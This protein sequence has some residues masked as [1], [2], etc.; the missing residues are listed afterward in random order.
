MTEIKELL[1]NI[2]TNPACLTQIDWREETDWFAKWRMSQL[3]MG[4]E[5]DEVCNIVEGMIVTSWYIACQGDDCDRNSPERSLLD[6]SWDGCYKCYEWRFDTVEEPF[7]SPK[8]IEAYM[9]GLKQLRENVNRHKRRLEELCIKAKGLGEEIAE[10]IASADCDGLAERCKELEAEC[11]EL[12][13]K[14]DEY[15]SAYE[16]EVERCA[17]LRL[18]I[19]N[20]DKR[21]KELETALERKRK[22]LIPVGQARTEA[23]REFVEQIIVYAEKQPVGAAR[24]IKDLLLVKSFNHHIS[25]ECLTDELRE[26]INKL[27]QEKQT[28]IVINSNTTD[29]RNSSIKTFY[30]AAE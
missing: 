20:K 9:E 25:E 24:E 19:R 14:N 21:I 6:E 8:S 16:G 18:E 7:P 11:N 26:R 27:G 29:I 10:K 23:I 15:W 30:E 17:E 4:I 28:N 3:F 12:K 13:K 1:A 5:D 2:N 22:K